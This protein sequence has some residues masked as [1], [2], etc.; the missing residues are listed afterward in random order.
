MRSKF[1]V[2]SALLGCLTLFFGV[3]PSR[4]QNPVTSPGDRERGARSQFP[5]NPAP[6]PIPLHGGAEERFRELD[7]NGDGLLSFDEMPEPLKAERDKWDVNRD[8][9]IDLSEW[10]EYFGVLVAEQR[11][12]ATNSVSRAQNPGHE[13]PIQEP[14]RQPR[15]PGGAPPSLN[16]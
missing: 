11:R 2:L 5:P 3:P 13:P 6:G 16:E 12:S 8:G 9:H 4:T 10:N 7:R 14:S 15:T 1:V